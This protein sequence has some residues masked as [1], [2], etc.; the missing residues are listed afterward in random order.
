MKTDITEERTEKMTIR[1]TL[2]LLQ[3]SGIAL[4]LGAMIGCN[5]LPEATD[6]AGFAY[7]P[8]QPQRF[9]RVADVEVSSSDSLESV[10]AQHQGTVISWHP[11]DGYATLGFM[12]GNGLRLQ[13]TSTN[14]SA[15]K[16]P[17]AESA[18]AAGL[19][20]WSSGWK[21]WAGGW[22][23]WAGGWKSWA[24]GDF[25]ATSD[26]NDEVWKKIKLPAATLLA[27][28]AGKDVIVAVIDTGIDVEHPAFKG[29][30]TDSSTWWDWVGGDALPQE[31]AGGS[32]Y[33]HGTCVAGIVLQIAPRAKIMPLRVLG[34]DGY[35]DTAHVIAAIGWAVSRGAKVI[36]LSLGTTKDASLDKALGNAAS[37][38]V[39]IVASSGNT[40]D[41]NVT[42]PA[43]SS[44]RLGTLGAMM[45]GVGSTGL[46]DQKSKFSTYGLA[47]FDTTSIGEN[48]SS[49]VPEDRIGV[50]SG[51]SMAA[52]M[53]SGAFAL[54]LGERQFT[55]LKRL[56]LAIGNT[57]D[58]LMFSD[59][60]Y[61]IMLGGRLNLERFLKTVFS[62][63]YR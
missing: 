55:D 63:N 21:S 58:N 16:S 42:Y 2:R 54:A 22:K 31:E 13:S 60:T 49:A 40:G 46:S 51:T 44:M 34:K 14:I 19:S 24:G 20:S 30:L 36:N 62:P 57:N 43:S 35:G 12:A 17:S 28:K 18:S 8:A 7:H 5:T 23:S 25:S 59:S 26:Q 9:E 4:V 47:V 1:P 45:V 39:L 29:S 38:G 33:G 52:P 10:S 53:I 56:G 15:Y 37:K 32:S 3:I 50:W 6:P 11:E 61:W 27:P 48:I 41:Q